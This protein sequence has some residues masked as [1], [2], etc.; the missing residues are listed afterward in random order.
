MRSHPPGMD[1]SLAIDRNRS[2]LL[3]VVAAIAALLGA[4]GSGLIARGLRH[5]ALALLRPAESAA[6]RLIILAARGLVLSP[7]PAP[8]FAGSF[9]GGAGAGRV[10]AFHLFD[11]AKRL[12]RRALLAPPAGVPRIRS[13]FGPPLVF[14]PPVP[15]RPAKPAPSPLV[16]AGR[17]RRRLAALERA[18]ATLPRQA[19][20]LAR[21][22]A[23]T[24][25]RRSPLRPGPPPGLRRRGGRD[26]DHVL[27][28]C[29][30]LALDVL[31]DTS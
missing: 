23:R 10:P 3:A 28:E 19:R 4:T 27:R 31:A 16:E 21:W 9:G 17:L 30:A 24:R 12:P 14:L 22:R 7:R 15:V 20:R 29:H 8:A 2:G 1:W 18:L 5:A 25:L 6:R 13:F 26:I 11:R